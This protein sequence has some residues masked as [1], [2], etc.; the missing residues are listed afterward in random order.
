MYGYATPFSRR[1]WRPRPRSKSV[2][3]IDRAKDWTEWTHVSRIVSQNIETRRKSTLLHPAATRHD[4]QWFVIKIL[5]PWDSSMRQCSY[6]R[7][8]P[9]WTSAI[10][11]RGR[12]PFISALARTMATALERLRQN[13][14]QKPRS[15]PSVYV[16][17]LWSRVLLASC[18]RQRQNFF[19]CFVL[20]MRVAR[21]GEG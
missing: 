10:I 3:Y 18:A 11:F 8:S 17:I 19:I 1:L 20:F 7:H 15:R 14:R 21:P 5:S 2:Y 9:L 6:E 12:T 4:S 16:F 13:H